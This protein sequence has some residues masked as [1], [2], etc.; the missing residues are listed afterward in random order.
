MLWLKIKETTS[1]HDQNN[2]SILFSDNKHDNHDEFNDESG[3]YLL[4]VIN[5]VSHI[6]LC[7]GALQSSFD[8]GR[9][10]ARTAGPSQREPGYANMVFKP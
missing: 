1:N 3:E 9:A 2:A 7:N 5:M 4:D 10:I 8:I 6:Q